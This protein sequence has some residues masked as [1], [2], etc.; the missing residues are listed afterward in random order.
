M[1]RSKSNGPNQADIAAAL[2]LSVST[3]S[4]ALSNAPGISDEVRQ[5]VAQAAVQF[6]YKTRGLGSHAGF[7]RIV[8]VATLFDV[9]G[10]LSWVYQEMLEGVLAAARQAG[11]PAESHI[12][13]ETERL[14]NSVDMR[15][16]PTVGLVL[17]GLQPD[18]ATIKALQEADISSVVVNGV[19]PGFT[20]DSVSPANYF[21][22]RVVAGHLAG[23]GHSKVGFVGGPR[24][25]TLMR[26]FHGF[27]DAFYD[28]WGENEASIETL[29]LNT[30]SAQS[31]RALLREWLSDLLQEATALFCYNDS[32]AISAMEAISTLGLS[33]PGDV[34]V[35]GYDDM[36]VALMSTPNLTTFRIDWRAIGREAL[37][38]LQLR[39]GGMIGDAR[40]IQ[41][42]GRLIVRESTSDRK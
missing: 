38:V 7:E 28:Y 3:V 20:V 8:I 15:L 11:L 41:I 21:G 22:G 4:R 9:N 17:L 40:E 5:R 6:G 19:D 37:Q 42:G 24:R 16:S 26:R 33:V 36:P 23:L 34:S 29:Y 2:N 30:G 31:Q 25:W 32:I 27:R 13:T 12:T 1:A 39:R 35:V 10:N 14:P 18:P